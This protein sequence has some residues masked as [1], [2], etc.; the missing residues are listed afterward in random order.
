MKIYRLSIY[1]MVPNGHGY[2]IL[3]KD[4]KT[5]ASA[6][7][8]GV[9]FAKAIASRE[10]GLFK[11][12]HDLV[13]VEPKSY[14]TDDFYIRIEDRRAANY[15]AVAYHVWVAGI[16]VATSALGASDFQKVCGLA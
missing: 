10:I 8:S 16:D 2:E 1:R 15:V 9:V 12:N 5:H 11:G 3:T 4:F 13:P 14:D 7:L 6:H